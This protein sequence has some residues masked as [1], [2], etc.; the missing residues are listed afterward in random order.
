[1][2]SGTQFP[3]IY[4]PVTDFTVLSTTKIELTNEVSAPETGQ[5]LIAIAI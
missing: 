3:Q 2:L 4:K 1:M 5:T